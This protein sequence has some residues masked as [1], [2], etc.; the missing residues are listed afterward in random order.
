MKAF[1]AAAVVA[2]VLAF[3]AH[4]GLQS[5]ELSSANTFSSPNVRL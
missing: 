1:V 2:V 5:L 3:G 4:F